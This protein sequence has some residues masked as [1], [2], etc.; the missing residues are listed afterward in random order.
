M[1][2]RVLVDGLDTATVTCPSCGGK[3]VI[4]VSA[5]PLSG[6]ETRVRA[7]CSCGHCCHVILE[8][9]DLRAADLQLPGTYTTHGAVKEYGRMTVRRLNRAGL[10]FMVTVG[11]DLFPGQKLFLEFVLDDVKQS[12]VRKE[13]VVAAANRRHV[14]VRFL[15]LDHFDNLGPYLFFNRLDVAGTVH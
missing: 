8:R 14:S 4:Q 3:K 11:R 1:M 2:E 6:P 13:G 7:R 5:L 10:V 15:S 9:L 12:I